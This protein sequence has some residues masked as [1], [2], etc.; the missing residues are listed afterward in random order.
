MSRPDAKKNVTALVRAYGSSRTLR[1]LANL[2]LI[3][4][5]TTKSVCFAEVKPLIC[6]G[7]LIARIEG[8]VVG[9]SCCYLLIF[10]RYV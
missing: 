2:V 4:V 3:L 9:R 1:D 6:P 5:G 10:I 8:C 7:S